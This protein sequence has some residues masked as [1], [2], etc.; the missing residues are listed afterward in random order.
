VKESRVIVRVVRAKVRAGRV[1]LFNVA[2]RRQLDLMREQPGLVYVKLARRLD[3]DGGEEVLLF[4]EWQD[5][6]S[7]YGWAGGDLSKA[8]LLPAAR[9]SVDEVTVT[10]YEALDVGIDDEGRFEVQEPIAT[11]REPVPDVFREPEG[12]SP[13]A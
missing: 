13:S 12:E 9:E 11:R 4:E 1:G 5:A 10:H 8:R 6:D 2:M 3:A 7:V